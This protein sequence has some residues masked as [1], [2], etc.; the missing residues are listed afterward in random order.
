[1][2]T[3]PHFTSEQKQLRRRI[4]EISF[5]NG[6]SHIGSCLGSVDIIDLIYQV[7]RPADSF[8]LS[9]GHAGIAY[10]VVLEKYQ[11]LKTELLEK[12]HIHPDRNTANG[13][14]TS[15]G[16]LGQGLPIT[17]GFALA[18]RKQHVFCLLSDG[19]CSEGSI[20]ESF[21]IIAEQHLSN[22]TCVINANG[23]GGYKKVSTS[24]LIKQTRGFLPTTVLSGRNISQLQETLQS[25]LHAKTP[26]VLLVKTEYDELQFLHG[27][28]AHYHVLTA[29]EYEL[30]E[31]I[32]AA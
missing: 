19:E 14:L 26:S 28:E 32:Y 2:N 27:Q 31:S 12:L 6:L 30:A 29:S 9:S 13:I 11:L 7:K 1:M 8:I 15:T 5:R 22:I 4:L 20:W 24:T 21:R 23:W 16:S 3:Q 10:Y 18:N 17:V 25:R